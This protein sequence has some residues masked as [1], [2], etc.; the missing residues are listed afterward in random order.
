M[1]AKDFPLPVALRETCER[2]GIKPYQAAE[3]LRC[4]VA[5]AYEYAGGRSAPNIAKAK[6]FSTFLD[7]SAEQFAVLLISDAEARRKFPAPRKSRT[8]HSRRS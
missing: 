7:M 3:A 5:M 4:S 2:R 8:K 1:E 6:E